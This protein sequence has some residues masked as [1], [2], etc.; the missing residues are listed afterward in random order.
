M[1]DI[2]ASWARQSVEQEEGE[3]IKELVA[4]FVMD[5]DWNPSDFGTNIVADTPSG[6]REFMFFESGEFNSEWSLI[7][8]IHATTN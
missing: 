6:F 8:V 5:T 7:E 1:I 3:T 2:I 4:N